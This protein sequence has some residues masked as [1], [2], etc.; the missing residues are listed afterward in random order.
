MRRFIVVMAIISITGILKAQSGDL[1]IPEDYLQSLYDQ[2]YV[3]QMLP[4]END[5]LS[6]LQEDWSRGW[7]VY[8]RDRNYEVL[9]NSKPAPEER[10]L[11]LR[12]VATPGAVESEPFS[13]YALSN[14][15][16]IGAAAKVSANDAS[17]SW[18]ET[19]TTVE[20][21]LFHPIQYLDREPHTWPIERFLRYPTFIRPAARYDMLNGTSR[22][23][24]VTVSV[25]DAQAPGTYHAS[26]KIADK[27][28]AEYSLPLEIEVLPFK[29]SDK[30]VPSFGA[31]MS[32]RKLA[33]GEWKFLDRYGFNA[34]FSLSGWGEGHPNQIKISN[35]NGMPR[36]D[37]TLYNRWVKEATD[38]GMSGPL[39]LFLGNSWLGHY[40]I[41]LSKALGL[42]LLNIEI[43]GV[44]CTL[45]DFKDPRWDKVWVEGI[46]Q[47]VAN[48]EK[49]RW[50]ELVIL[51]HDEP[52]KQLMA[53]HPHKYH[54]VKDNFPKLPVYGVFFQPQEDPGPLVT[55]CD[56]MVANRDL[57]Y[58]KS[59]ARRNGKRFWTYHNINADHSFGKNR[60]SYGQVPSY[61]DSEV[62]WFWSWNYYGGNP[63]NDFDGQSDADWNAV[64]PSIDGVEPVRTLAIEAAREAIDDVR[65]IK[66]LENMVKAKDPARWEDMNRELKRMQH[67]IFNGVD[68]DR[69]IYSDAD[70]FI[71]TRNDAPE[72]I[73]EW[74][75]GQILEELKP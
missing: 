19:A 75:I 33:S 3:E 41:A 68:F 39:V 47:V 54:L 61:Y 24:W 8:Q 28:G 29:L 14:V 48:A 26:I 44:K 64:Y 12:L 60:I 31:F 37:F 7:L 58:I 21:V 49:E 25:P 56:I 32:S 11:A 15:E 20:D 4:V 63:W 62:M 40:D 36:L 18:L 55:S 46:R 17:S 45:A 59:L 42:P 67:D 30:G 70:F 65:Y 74:V 38:A 53:Y 35:D 22:L 50:P 72:K 16:E 73:R 6:P 71:T 51:I 52:T 13:V 9:V 69:R 1:P 10:K 34:I 27:K 66:T 43:K 5:T 2:G 57:E 23:Y